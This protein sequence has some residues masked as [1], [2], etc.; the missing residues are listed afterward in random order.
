MGGWKHVTETLYALKTHF[1]Q[2]DVADLSVLVRGTAAV[3][4]SGEHPAMLR[5]KVC[6]PGGCSIG[7]LL[8]LE[9]AGVRGTVSR[10]VREAACIASQLGQGIEGVNGT[11]H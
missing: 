3:V 5:D 7:G 11:R 10:A 4:L 9:E 6:T 2:D 1:T 8:V